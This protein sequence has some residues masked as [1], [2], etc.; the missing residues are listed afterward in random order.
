VPKF[1]D[2][3]AHCS[4][5]R[6]L[7]SVSHSSMYISN[8]VFEWRS[9]LHVCISSFFS[10]WQSWSYSHATECIATSEQNLSKKRQ[11]MRV[12]SCEWETADD[13]WCHF[14]RGSPHTLY[15]RHP[16]FASILS[17]FHDIIWYLCSSDRLASYS[18][19]YDCFSQAEE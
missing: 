5:P 17:L 14:K 2:T 3:L 8:I 13:I 15:F 1:P 19:R 11:R 7:H 16:S 6:L 18:L 12:V 4:V 10:F 9:S